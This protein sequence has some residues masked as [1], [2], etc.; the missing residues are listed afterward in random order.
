MNGELPPKK[1]AAIS[2]WGNGTE[3]SRL[4]ALRKAALHALGPNRPFA[5]NIRLTLRVS[6]GRPR[7]GENPGDLDNF[8]TGVCDGLMAA[9]P[10]ATV[11][12]LFGK[13]E[14]ADVDPSKTIAIRDD[15][16]V[17]EINASKTVG[18]GTHCRYEVTLEGD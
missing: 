1:G 14:N 16:H 4:I 15:Q 10:R 11:H 12:P 13:E 2:M 18:P 6:V 5:Q 3:A 17:V 8:V 7:G 9:D